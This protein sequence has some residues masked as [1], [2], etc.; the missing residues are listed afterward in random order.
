M[1]RFTLLAV[2]LLLSG[3]AGFATAKQEQPSPVCNGLLH[4]DVRRDALHETL[5]HYLRGKTRKEALAQERARLPGCVQLVPAVG[6][7]PGLVAHSYAGEGGIAA[8][9]AWP[10]DEQW[11]TAPLELTDYPQGASVLVRDG[12]PLLAIGQIGA[13][14]GGFGRLVIARPGPSGILTATPVTDLHGKV[15]FDFLDARLI[16]MTYRG[17]L[18]GPAAWNCNACLPVNHQRLLYWHGMGVT[19]KGERVFTEPCL[20]ATLFLGAL[21]SGDEQLAGR[22]AQGPGIVKMV[23]QFP[24]SKQS[25]VFTWHAPDCWTAG[26]GVPEIRRLEMRNWDLIPP[27]YRTDLPE[28]L[29]RFDLTLRS[30]EERAILQMARG[31]ERWIVTGVARKRN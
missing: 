10:E 29:K 30:G 19:V 6:E 1:R 22:Y 7:L 23:K 20:T 13:G 28:H 2:F 17:A 3:Y 27:P 12:K 16:L 9:F 8:L 5:T 21:M 4:L 25:P 18:P 15:R 26:G 14:S 11:Q 31:P 24:A